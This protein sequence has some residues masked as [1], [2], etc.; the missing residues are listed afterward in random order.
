MNRG[1][2]GLHLISMLVEFLASTARFLGGAPGT[3]GKIMAYHKVNADI[4]SSYLQGCNS[5]EFWEPFLCNQ[6]SLE[7]PR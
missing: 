5:L 6:N 4:V 3:E 1:R 7:F 2:I